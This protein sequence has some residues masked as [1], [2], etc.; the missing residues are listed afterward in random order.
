M[1]I[2]LAML[3]MLAVS[4]LMGCV[5]V[6]VN[7]PVPAAVMVPVPPPPPPPLLLP[8]PPLPLLPPPLL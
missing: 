5:V 3:G 4:G 7:G 2:V 8:P 1:R 6:P